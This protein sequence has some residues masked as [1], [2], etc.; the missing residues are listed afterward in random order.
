MVYFNVWFI[1]SYILNA[2]VFKLFS[3]H[4]FSLSSITYSRSACII[5]IYN[6]NRYNIRRAE[7]QSVRDGRLTTIRKPKRQTV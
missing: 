3:K 6:I 2:I 1:L 5:C 7:C 4:Y